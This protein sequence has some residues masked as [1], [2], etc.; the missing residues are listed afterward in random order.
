M[1]HPVVH[2]VVDLSCYDAQ[3][4]LVMLIVPGFTTPDGLPFDSPTF[5]GPVSN[6]RF[7][8]NV[9]RRAVHRRLGSWA[10]TLAGLRSIGTSTL[11]RTLFTR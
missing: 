8:S 7:D 10:R 6:I 9:Y 1:K 4:C 3:V 5:S 2:A 11:A